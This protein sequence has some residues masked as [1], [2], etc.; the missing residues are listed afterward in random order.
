MRLAYIFFGGL[1]NLQLHLRTDPESP[2]CFELLF[3]PFEVVRQSVGIAD[4]RSTQGHRRE[5]VSDH[6]GLMDIT[7]LRVVPDS[8]LL[9]TFL[10]R[11]FMG[12]TIAKVQI[13]VLVCFLEW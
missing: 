9:S 4:R 11:V 6:D 7:E 3:E 13:F 2:P 1:D 12:N 5:A 10:H 8:I